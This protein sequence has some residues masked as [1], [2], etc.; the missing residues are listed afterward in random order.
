MRPALQI[1]DVSGLVHCGHKAPNYDTRYAHNFPV[2]G[3]QYLMKHVVS[4]LMSYKD[5][6][7]TFDGRN[8]FRKALYK[9]YKLGRP[10]NKQVWAQLDLLKQI[11]PKCG[12]RCIE[13]DTLEADDLVFNVTEANDGQWDY[14]QIEILGVDY[15]L[16]HNI[17][18]GHI[19]FHSVSSQVNCV[20]WYDFPTAM[21]P[22]EEIIHNTIAAYKIFCGDNSDKIPTFVAQGSG[23]D[24][25]ALYAQYKKLIKSQAGKLS[26]KQIR[27]EKLLRLYIT[28]LGG[29]LN[30]TDRIEL[31]RRIKLVYPVI[32]TDIDFKKVTSKDD[33]VMDSLV[34]FLSAI[35][36]RTSLKTLKKTIITPSEPLVQILKGTAKALISGE[37][38]VDN[39]RQVA[40]VGV[41]TECVNL[42]GF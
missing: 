4:D 38:A 18:D 16:T 17:T 2:G 9:G 24:G 25:K 41:N 22:N 19:A 31:D 39:N 14:Q 34:D 1:Y 11:L 20:N 36:D 40:G 10:A 15:D 7:L 42:K 5:V 21:Y 32:V 29:L 12:I 23:Y 35:G 6:I 3:M 27:S 13:K 8:N 30:D 26:I 33:I 28:Q 37:Y